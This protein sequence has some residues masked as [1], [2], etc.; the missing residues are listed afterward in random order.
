MNSA[1]T[2]DVC[3]NAAAVSFHSTTSCRRSLSPSSGT[4]AMRASGAA[5]TAPRSVSK[6]PTR[7]SMPSRANRSA[8]YS[9]VPVS[10]PASSTSETVMSNFAA[11]ASISS[12]SMRSLGSTT[13]RIGA[14]WSAKV[15]CTSGVRPGSRPRPS[16]SM[17][18]S[19][20]RSWWA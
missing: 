12:G 20:G 14:F 19:N 17:S 5:A 1:G 18:R 7:R 11:P 6:C 3:G 8:L 2:E 9:I 13:S 4:A 15:T 10:P 16:S